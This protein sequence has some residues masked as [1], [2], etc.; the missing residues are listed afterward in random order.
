M[1]SIDL[2]A[3]LGIIFIIILLGVL[4]LIPTEKMGSLRRKRRRKNEGEDQKDWQAVSLKLERHIYALRREIE[5]GQNRIKELEREI[6]LQNEKSKRLREKLSQERGWKDKEASDL[7]KKSQE[8]I[9]LKLDLKKAEQSLEKEHGQR[10]K[11]E[12]G[13]K[14]AKDNL[15]ETIAKQRELEIEIARQ[16]TQMDKLHSELSNLREENIKLSK[17]HDEATFIAKSEYEKLEKMFKEKD[18]ELQDFKRQ[19]QREGR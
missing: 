3:V 13:L 17:K 18:H 9:H 15:S 6:L 16:K 11:A 7:E 14:E 10:L 5:S 4:L 8:I 12:R 19:I 1:P 2:F